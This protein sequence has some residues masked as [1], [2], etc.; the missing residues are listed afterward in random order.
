MNQTYVVTRM[1]AWARESMRGADGGL[2]FKNKVSFVDPMPPSTTSDYT[3]D[4]DEEVNEMDECVR[5]LGRNYPEL[6]RVIYFHYL[7]PDLKTEDKLAQ[8]DCCKQTF[9]NRIGIAHQYLLGWLNDL[10]AG[11]KIN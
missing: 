11:I 5:A 2:G 10:A 4:I 3:P 8:L 1:C 7:R 6:Y 9:Y